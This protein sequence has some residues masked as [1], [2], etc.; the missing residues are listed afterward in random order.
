MLEQEKKIFV[1]SCSIHFFFFHRQKI[2]LGIFTQ[3]FVELCQISLKSHVNSLGEWPFPPPPPLEFFWEVFLFKMG[4]PCFRVN[5]VVLKKILGF[6]T[7]VVAEIFWVKNWKILAF[8]QNPIFH[9]QKLFFSKNK[10]WSWKI[11]FWEKPK[12]SKF[13]NFGECKMK[14]FSL[15]PPP[16][17]VG[18]FEKN[19]EIWMKL[20]N[21]FLQRQILLK[22]F[23]LKNLQ[24]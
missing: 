1:R 11:G 7:F 8:S 22:M 15:P 2:L 5:F 14:K 21:F 13:F 16:P 3:N 19:Y 10:F 18:N 6:S 4:P 9:D 20:R 24:H 17:V 12:I 23:D